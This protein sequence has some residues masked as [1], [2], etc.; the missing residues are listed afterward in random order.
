VLTSCNTHEFH[1]GGVRNDASHA[2]DNITPVPMVP[3]MNNHLDPLSLLGIAEP[4]G[5]SQSLVIR[6]A[7]D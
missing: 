4:D 1:N 6:K 7:G 5:D 2:K 3:W